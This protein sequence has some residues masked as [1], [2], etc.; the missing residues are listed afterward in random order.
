MSKIPICHSWLCHSWG[1]IPS[2][3]LSQDMKNNLR[4]FDIQVIF[5][6]PR[7]IG[8]YPY[9]YIH[10]SLPCTTYWLFYKSMIEGKRTKNNLIGRKANMMLCLGSSVS[11]FDKVF[12]LCYR[13]SWVIWGMLIHLW[14]LRWLWNKY[15]SMQ[16]SNFSKTMNQ[17]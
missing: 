1:K 17:I 2:I 8:K 4:L 14:Y 3:L 7:I 11:R 9:R 12:V 5:V 10:L 15:F 13:K 16:A 6:S